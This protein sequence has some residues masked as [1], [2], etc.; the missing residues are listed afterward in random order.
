MGWLGYFLERAIKV[1][2]AIAA[3]FALSCKLVYPPTSMDSRTAGHHNLMYRREGLLE[4]I[5]VYDL[6]Q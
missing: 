5:T 2:S 3:S 4:G 6:D 1:P